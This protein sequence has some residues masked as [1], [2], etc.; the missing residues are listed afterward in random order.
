MEGMSTPNDPKRPDGKAQDAQVAATALAALTCAIRA[1]RVY[2]ADHPAG[3]RALDRLLEAMSALAAGGGARTIVCCGRT[4]L[5]QGSALPETPETQECAEELGAAD[6]SVLGVKGTPTREALGRVVGAFANVRHGQP[7]AAIAPLNEA[8]AGLLEFHT[9]RADQL[10]FFAPGEEREAGTWAM[11]VGAAALGASPAAQRALQREM[12]RIDRALR[13][14][15]GIAPGDFAGLVG[16][17]LDGASAVRGGPTAETAGRVLRLNPDLRAALL[18]I[19]AA[20]PHSGST[21]LNDL[22]GHLPAQEVVEA[23]SQVSRGGVAPPEASVLL[24][25]KLLHLTSD[26]AGGGVNPEGPQGPEAS[27][28]SASLI[29]ELLIRRGADDSC[30]PEYADHLA[31][32]AAEPRLR[33][34][35]AP[36]TDEFAADALAVRSAE[37]ATYLLRDPVTDANDRVRALEQVAASL[38]AVAATSRLDI[39]SDALAM[40]GELTGAREPEIARAAERL[41]E[42]LEHGSAVTQLVDR[43]MC[44]AHTPTDIVQLAQTMGRPLVRWAARQ[45]ESGEAGAKSDAVRM[46]AQLVPDGI[47]YEELAALFRG[48]SKRGALRF[49][50]L[51]PEERL[52]GAAAALLE[53]ADAAMLAEILVVLHQRGRRLSPR[54]LM[55]AF[56]LDDPRALAVACGQLRES[57]ESLGTEALAGILE[58]AAAGSNIAVVHAVA[59]AL[60]ARPDGGAARLAQILGGLN[61]G[62]S[63]SRARVCRAL[64]RVLESR[65]G[66]AEVG[67]TLARWKRSPLFALSL[68]VGDDS[69]RREAA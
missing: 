42:S 7:G 57:P 56:A 11:L 10:G 26:S 18:R 45:L 8:G 13:A 53:S 37:I 67:P 65:R 9:L 1:V 5:F 16:E 46:I 2:G 41:V 43:V 51:I 28:I 25:K 40:A 29:Q 31:T 4:I 35:F 15:P 34:S 39:A 17:A 22:S 49:L 60:V 30:V 50:G 38:P 12:P 21:W 36:S 62:L 23:I 19:A 63:V 48:G 61:Q 33:A 58:K 64:A 6:V 68:L 66:Q 14:D 27:A 52:P 59:D 54:H 44:R 69:A 24:L 20:D 3:G 55:A 32:T 47:A